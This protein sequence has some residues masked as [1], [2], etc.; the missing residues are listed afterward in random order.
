MYYQ[1]ELCIA[2]DPKTLAIK[3]KTEHDDQF[4]TLR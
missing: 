3:N 1:S 2:L 4:V